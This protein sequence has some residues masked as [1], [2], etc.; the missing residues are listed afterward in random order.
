MSDHT[1][2]REAFL[3]EFEILR[4]ALEAAL[5]EPS[6][7]SMTRALEVV[8]E[9]HGKLNALGY[10]RAGDGLVTTSGFSRVARLTKTAYRGSVYNFVLSGAGGSTQVGHTFF[11]NDILVGDLEMQTALLK[12]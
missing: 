8:N 10:L 5:S 11:A 9:R 12:K 2:I 3:E 4:S 1:R 6:P 7:A